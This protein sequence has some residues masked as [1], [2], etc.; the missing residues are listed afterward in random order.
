MLVNTCTHMCVWPSRV[1]MRAVAAGACC[2]HAVGGRA[3]AASNGTTRAA[4][5][6]DADEEVGQE[7]KPDA[8]GLV[9]GGVQGVGAGACRKELG[10]QAQAPRQA[11]PARAAGG[12]GGAAAQHGNAHVWRPRV[13]VDR[14][15][16]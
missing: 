5:L 3:A 7:L 6:A 9:E 12:H 14:R 8:H 16:P 4:H 11:V 2:L 13:S 1:R 10:L 15:Q